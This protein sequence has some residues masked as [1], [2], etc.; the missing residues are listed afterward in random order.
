MFSEENRTSLKQRN[1]VPYTD[2]FT[3]MYFFERQISDLFVL[4]RIGKK[5]L[6]QSKKILCYWA[7]DLGNILNIQV[8]FQVW[9]QIILFS[10]NT[11]THKVFFVFCGR[12]ARVMQNIWAVTSITPHFFLIV[13]F[14]I[15][16]Q[17]CWWAP[18]CN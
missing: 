11:Q 9:F 17:G 2:F 8:L 4:K 18:K 13:Y 12:L 7:V 1:S 6:L 10:T 14:L 15:V 16:S 5:G 3:M